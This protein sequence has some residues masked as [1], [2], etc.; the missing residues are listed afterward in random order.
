MRKSLIIT[1]T[2]ALLLCAVLCTAGCVT[3]DQIPGDWLY[4]T[5]DAASVLHFEA[6]ETGVLAELVLSETDE[7]VYEVSAE[8]SFTWKNT[9]T[10][11][12]QLTFSDETVETVAVDMA[13]GTLVF[14]GETYEKQPSE[15]SGMA[16]GGGHM[17]EGRV[18]LVSA[19]PVEPVEVMESG[20]ETN[21]VR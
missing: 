4:I 17:F 16:T 9:G 3:E 8:T 6:D 10:S 5:D 13:K 1:I 20:W 21:D 2:A 11:G 19:L 15:L 12:Y 7:L 18:G 14:R